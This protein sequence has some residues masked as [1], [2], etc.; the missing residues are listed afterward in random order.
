MN[1]QRLKEYRELKKYSAPWRRVK[2]RK[3]VMATLTQTFKH[4]SSE[5]E[6]SVSHICPWRMRVFKHFINKG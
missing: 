6:S 5:K 2:Q 1:S 4:V 3:V